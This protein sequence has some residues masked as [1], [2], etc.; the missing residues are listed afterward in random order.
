MKDFKTLLITLHSINNPG[1]ALQAYALNR[2]LNDNGIK[3]EIID[4][5]PYYSK[6]GTQ[7]IKGII[8]TIVFYPNERETNRKYNTFVKKYMKLTRK[9]YFLYSQLK[10]KSPEADCYIVGSDQ[11]WNPDYECGKD[12]AYTLSFIKGKDKIAYATS[13]GKPTLS[14]SELENLALRIED[15]K[16]ISVREKSTSKLLSAKMARDVSWVCDPV[17][18]LDSKDYLNLVTENKYGD[19]AV[20]YL[21]VASPMLDKYIEYLRSVLGLKI[22]QAGG[23]LKR[24]NCDLHLKNIGPEEFL[25]L[26][27]HAKFV[28]SGSFHATAFSLLFKKSFCAFLPESNGERILSILSLTGL[29]SRIIRQENDFSEATKAIDY[30]VVDAELSLFIEKSRNKLIDEVSEI[31]NVE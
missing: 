15:F 14:E 4:Y 11:L 23:N 7:I 21:A 22:I 17:F 31:K 2:F 20:M 18:L 10:N 30:S 9:R 1:S 29:E 8:R 3:N 24:C 12:S 27:Q 6:I 16:W 13:V 26:I 19:Y 25:T 5:R 28:I